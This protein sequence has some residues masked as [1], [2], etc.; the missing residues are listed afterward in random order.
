MKY[1]GALIVA[2]IGD[3]ALAMQLEAGTL[4]RECRSEAQ[5]IC[6]FYTEMHFGGDEY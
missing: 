5:K 3:A 1:F 6:S 4:M 2:L